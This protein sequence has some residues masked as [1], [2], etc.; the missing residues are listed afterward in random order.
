MMQETKFINQ[1]GQEERMIE[2]F[3]APHSVDGRE[4]LLEKMNRRLF[5]LEEQG[6]T[7]VQQKPITL[8]EKMTLEKAKKAKKKLSRMERKR[9]K[10][11]ELVDSFF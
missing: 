1:D 6:H 5:A 7:L 8:A 11:N 9:R 2:I 3:D 4:R 10:E